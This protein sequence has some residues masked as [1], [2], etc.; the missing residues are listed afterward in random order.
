MRYCKPSLQFNYLEVRLD[1]F[2]KEASEYGITNLTSFYES[3][4]F[5]I[6]YKIADKKILCPL[7]F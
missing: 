4:N 2:E 7:N 6:K 5:K 1:A 3:K